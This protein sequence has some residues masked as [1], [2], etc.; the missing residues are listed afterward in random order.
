MLRAPPTP[1]VAPY[2]AAYDEGASRFHIAREM[3]PFSHKG[4]RAS[5]L[6]QSVVASACRS[7]SLQSIRSQSAIRR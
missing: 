2:G 4:R 3:T 1:P 5:E 7:S 6:N